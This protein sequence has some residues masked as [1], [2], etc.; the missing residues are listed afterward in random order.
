MWG[1]ARRTTLALASTALV[2]G[3]MAGCGGSDGGGSGSAAPDNASKE[4]FCGAFAKL[5]KDILAQATSGDPDVTVKAIKDWAADMQD[6]GTPDD[7]PDD[8]RDGFEI[9]VDAARDLPED[10]SLEDLQ[11]FGDDLS[12]DDQAA[13]EKFGDWAS[14]ECPDALLPGVG[15]L[16]SDLPTELPSDL[17]SDLPTELPSELESLMSDLPTDPSELES[18]MSELT[19]DAN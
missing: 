5:F 3:T 14:Q 15:E 10:A 18:M 17:A 16:A 6:V 13:G 4:D 11:T 12:E 2:L 9:F 7:M 19:A 8:V 1:T